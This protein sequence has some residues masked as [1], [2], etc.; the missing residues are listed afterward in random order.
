MV[1][2]GIQDFLTA[3][4]KAAERFAMYDAASLPKNSEIEAALVSRQRLFGGEQYDNTLAEQRRIAADVMRMLE[5]FEP[6]LVGAVL[7]GS[8]TE[9]ADIQL[10][11]FSDSAES[12]FF[13]LMDRRINYE[14]VERRVKMST[15]RQL[16][17]PGAKFVVGS[18]TIE[19]LVFPADGI[20]Q[21][22]ISP[23]DGKPM[24]RA[25]LSEVSSLADA[26]GSGGVR[27]TF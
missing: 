13:D 3:K 18:A 17:M 7:S 5:K 9:Y 10:H 22:P 26:K 14:V 20:R 8:A 12:V 23:V 4:N 21:A 6:R 11:L 25:S 1:E 27:S 19:A 15:D 16:T 24:R 2:H